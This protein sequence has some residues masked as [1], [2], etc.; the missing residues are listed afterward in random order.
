MVGFE[1]Q[2][3][4]FS[5]NHMLP[6]FTYAFK[7]NLYLAKFMELLSLLQPLTLMN[8]T[9]GF[10]RRKETVSLN[11]F[12]KSTPLVN[13]ITVDLLPEVFNCVKLLPCHFTKAR[14]LSV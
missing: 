11:F 10:S 9:V 3:I 1:N 2:K 7:L 8:G 14:D 12:I 6:K 13:V 4:A 5:Y